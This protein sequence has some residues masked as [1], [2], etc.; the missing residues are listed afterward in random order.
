MR[1]RDIISRYFAFPEGNG[2]D[3][4]V[5]DDAAV[6]TPPVGA[7]LA[8]STDT[9]AVNT[10]FFADVSPYFLA[11]KAAAVSLSDMAAMAA[12]PLWLTVALTAP[13]AAAD[14]FEAFARGLCD[15][16]RD[17]HYSIVG[18]DLTRGVLTVTTTAIGFCEKKALTRAAAADGDDIWLSGCVGEAAHALA[19]AQGRLPAAAMATAQQRLHNPSPRLALGRA[20]AEV[21]SAAMDLSDGLLAAANAM[22]T[23]SNVRLLLSEENMPLPPSLQGLDTDAR[24]RCLFAGG[25][26]YELLFTAPAAA[27]ERVGGLATAEVPLTIIGVVAAGDGVRLLHHGEEIR[28][29]NDGYEHDFGV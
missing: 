2:V 1:E 16:A 24:R 20:L 12:T 11:R 19:V 29:S 5:G 3:I 9:L 25:D 15:S 26:D 6:L 22:A 4:G 17:Y 7:S 8:V 18:G 21:A 10:H 14:W 13:A 27:R 23:A 28:L